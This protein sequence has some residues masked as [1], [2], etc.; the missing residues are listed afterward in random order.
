MAPVEIVPAIVLVCPRADLEELGFGGQ[1][2]G[3][4]HV[5]EEQ[6]RVDLVRTAFPKRFLGL[7]HGRHVAVVVTVSWVHPLVRWDVTQR[8]RGYEVV[9]ID[10][11]QR[12]SQLHRR[13]IWD[14][15]NF[16]ECG[17]IDLRLAL[18]HLPE[19]LPQQL[20]AEVAA[21]VEAGGSSGD[22][23][24]EDVEVLVAEIG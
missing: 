22:R 6:E 7:V 16:P 20:R 5:L 13:D 21:V 24:G 10:E 18:D 14:L 3:F 2:R 15:Q 23:S 1:Q 9:G 4:R 12:V 11:T 19:Q 8:I 17:R